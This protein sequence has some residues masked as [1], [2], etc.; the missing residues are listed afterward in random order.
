MKILDYLKNKSLY[1][2]LPDLQKKFIDDLDVHKKNEYI[3]FLMPVTTILAA[4]GVTI[5]GVN[6]F[7]YLSFIILGWAM[8]ALSVII[9]VYLRSDV[10]VVQ[11]LNSDPDGLKA[12]PFSLNY[13]KLTMLISITA[14]F[15]YSP[16]YGAI[17]VGCIITTI[18]GSYFAM[19]KTEKILIEQLVEH[20]PV[21]VEV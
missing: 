20:E 21:S 1:E 9:I 4:Y 8:F 12:K 3:R 7:A 19:K 11:L 2:T 17:Y 14:S 10:S 13:D 15:I 6:I 18:I 5:G 16:I